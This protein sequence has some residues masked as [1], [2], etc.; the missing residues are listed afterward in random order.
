MNINLLQ[1]N[2]FDKDNPKFLENLLNEEAFDIN[3]CYAVHGTLLCAAASRYCV[4]TINFLLDEGADINAK[5]TDGK[6]PLHCAIYAHSKDNQSSSEIDTVQLLMD[7]GADL[8]EQDNTGD[9]PLRMAAKLDSPS[10]F[11]LLIDTVMKPDDADEM[12]NLIQEGLVDKNFFCP[13]YDISA[14]CIAASLYSIDTALVLLE[15][16]AAVNL[17]GTNGITPLHYAIGAMHELR[18]SGLIFFNKAHA[19]PE[20]MVDILLYYG[21]GNHNVQDNEGNTPLHV[22]SI[23]NAPII[24]KKLISGGAWRQSKTKNNDGYTAEQL[25][26]YQ[27]QEMEE[28]YK[29]PVRLPLENHAHYQH[30]RTIKWKGYAEPDFMVPIEIIERNDYRNMERTVG[31]LTRA[32]LAYDNF[33]TSSIYFSRQGVVNDVIKKIIKLPFQDGINT[34]QKAYQL[35]KGIGWIRSINGVVRR[36]LYPDGDLPSYFIE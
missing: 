16:G 15:A 8:Y 24:I 1:C 3:Y 7:R 20:A 14:L 6:T 11:M 19:A 13:D 9:T 23:R 2:V 17:V 12:H 18:Y 30:M 22:A 33:V 5:D 31:L 10:T 28:W 29:V 26:L 21:A 34:P 25:A 35:M 4:N 32:R 27:K 36:I